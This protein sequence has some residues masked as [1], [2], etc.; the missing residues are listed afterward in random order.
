MK[1]KSFY[2]LIIGILVGIFAFQSLLIII[3]ELE[4]PTG[5]QKIYSKKISGSLKH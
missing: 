4:Y 2:L 5:I 1:N 3:I